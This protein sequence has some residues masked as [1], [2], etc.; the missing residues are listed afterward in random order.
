MKFYLV[1]AGLG[2]SMVGRSIHNE[3]PTMHRVGHKTPRMDSTTRRWV[4]QLGF[5]LIRRVVRHPTTRRAS[6]TTRRG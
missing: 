6:P 5:V 2:G 1:N 3:D 4:N